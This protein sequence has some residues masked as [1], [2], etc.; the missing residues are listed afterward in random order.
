MAQKPDGI[1][2]DVHLANTTAAPATPAMEAKMIILPEAGYM[3][4]FMLI[5]R[6]RQP[7]RAA[8]MDKGVRE[9]KW[10]GMSTSGMHF[11]DCRPQVCR[12]K[13]ERLRSRRRKTSPT[14]IPRRS[15]RAAMP[16]RRKM[17]V[18]QNVLDKVSERHRKPSRSASIPTITSDFVKKYDPTQSGRRSL[19]AMCSYPERQPRRRD[20][21]HARSAP[22][23]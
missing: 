3:G 21:G 7:V 8:D 12:L 19:P 18:F 11:L 15:R 17:V 23:L 22:R 14:P 1:Q 13:G 4:Y 20:D 2:Q 10:P 9:Q 6:R 16:Y 5:C